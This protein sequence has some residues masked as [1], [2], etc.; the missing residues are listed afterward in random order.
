MAVKHSR[1]EVLERIDS[2]R[3]TAKCDCGKVKTYILAN[4]KNGHT[5]S[6]GCLAKEY[7]KSRVGEKSNFYKHGQ[8]YEQGKRTAEFIA[9][10]AMNGRCY[11]E[12]DPSYKSYGGRG[13]D[14]C[15]EWRDSVSHF[16]ADMGEQ[17][18]NKSLDRID[19]SKGYS[20]ENC[21]WATKKEQA[22]N[23]RSTRFYEYNGQRLSL[24]D[25]SRQLNIKYTTLR[26]RIDRGRSFSESVEMSNAN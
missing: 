17:P 2:K 11:N 21:R 13:I 14:V 18:K 8:T 26:H 3:V 25:W 23:R 1:L 9:W 16:I 12:K 15:K 4:I 6:C 10:Q 5:K 24:S 19:N 7:A 22:D 20:K